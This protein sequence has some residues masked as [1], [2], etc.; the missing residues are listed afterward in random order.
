MGD[1]INQF[2]VPLPVGVHSGR[3]RT[4]RPSAPSAVAANHGS[5]SNRNNKR[6]LDHL[7]LDPVS[8]GRGTRDLRSARSVR[9]QLTAE[10]P[11]GGRPL[12]ATG[13]TLVSW[14][15]FL[16]CLAWLPVNTCTLRTSDLLVARPGRA[17]A[18]HTHPS[19]RYTHNTPLTPKIH[20]GTAPF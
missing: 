5:R 11:V 1:G 14:P 13:S 2:A 19:D 18:L 6:D 8:R 16:H 17:R 12:V 9:A 15:R 4:G 20:F 10:G 3:W 7:C